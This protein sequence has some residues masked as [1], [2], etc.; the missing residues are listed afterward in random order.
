MTNSIRGFEYC[1]RRK[2]ILDELRMPHFEWWSIPCTV[3][4]YD[5]FKYFVFNRFTR[6]RCYCNNSYI[7]FS[8]SEGR[9]YCLCARVKKILDEYFDR[10][11]SDIEHVKDFCD[12]RNIIPIRF[13]D[14]HM[15]IRDL[16]ELNLEFC[17]TDGT[18]PCAVEEPIVMQLKDC[19][20]NFFRIMLCH[21]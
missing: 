9:S 3:T 20:I 21:Q 6:T 8:S 12:L 18:Q 5:W 4:T 15:S 2:K 17:A 16:S 1:S 14:D 7:K 10:E 11:R 19:V 13:F